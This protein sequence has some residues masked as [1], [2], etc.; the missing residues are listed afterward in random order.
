[1]QEFAGDEHGQVTL[2]AAWLLQ[3]ANAPSLRGVEA[4]QVNSGDAGSDALAAAMSRALA[5]LSDRIAAALAAHLA[6]EKSG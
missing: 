4:L 1:V 5:D 6:S 2:R 3:S